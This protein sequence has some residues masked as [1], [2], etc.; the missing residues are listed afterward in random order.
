M[1]LN[2]LYLNISW[3]KFA[4]KKKLADTTKCLTSPE[5]DLD[6]YIDE[7][8]DFPKYYVCIHKFIGCEATKYQILKADPICRHTVMPL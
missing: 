7:N 5:H 4:W 6:A 2:P 8:D 3:N 1:L